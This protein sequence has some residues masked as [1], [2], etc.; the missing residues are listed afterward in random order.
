MPVEDRAADTWEPLVAIA[1]AAGGNWPKRIRT[2]VL[3]LV[4]AEAASDAEASLGIRLLFDI[5]DVF[6]TWTVSFIAS[7]DLLAALNKIDDAPWRELNL[8]AR[9][10]ADR[11][12]PYGIKPT[13][14][15]GGTARGYRLEDFGDAFTRYAR[16]NP[17]NRQSPAQGTVTSDASDTSSVRRPQA[18]DTLSSQSDSL[19]G[20]DA[21]LWPEG[22]CGLCGQPSQ[23]GVCWDCTSKE[24]EEGDQP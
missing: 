8:T 16:Q 7:T 22:R 12:R 2:A 4:A 9:G 23:H 20:S 1:D 19:T 14:N 5:R 6:T 24:F 3:R 10:I 17:S 11:L 18:S 21:P 13:R 15:T